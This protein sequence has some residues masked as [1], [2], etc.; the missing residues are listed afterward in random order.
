M[1]PVS[2]R[3][4]IGWAGLA[5]LALGRSGLAA[6]AS[7][8]FAPAAFEATADSVLL[9]VCGN[10]ASKLRIELEEAGTGR[11]VAG[12]AV[13]LTREGDFTAT[14]SVTGLSPGTAWTYRVLDAESGR[15]LHKPGA[16]K[17]APAG[18][19]PFRFVFTADMEESYQPFSLFDV[20]EKYQ[21]DFFLL[22]GDTI[23]ADH[24]KRGF[25]PSISHYRGKHAANRRDA[26]LQA[27]LSRRTT[28]ATW[29]DH[30]VDDNA[31]G[32]HPN[33]AEG[34]QVFREYWPCRSVAPDSLYRRFEWAGVDFFMLDTRRH[35][36]PQT[37]PEDAAKTMLGAAQKAWLLDGLAASKAPFRFIV[38]TVP[39]GGG[40]ADTWGNYKTE[41][42]EIRRFLAQK[43]MR[44]AIFLTGDY[45]LARDWSNEKLG[46]REYMAG[47]I[48]SFFHYQRTPAAR[49][50][51]EKLGAFHYGDG[52]N[53]G[54]W[55][56][57]PAAGKAELEFVD[58]RGET[59]HRVELAA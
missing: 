2:R 21:P 9:W 23:Y 44:N 26:R 18:P 11:R 28:F 8:A 51:Y 59:M 5:P 38:T 30:E 57:D 34:L 10:E 43:K 13:A 31:H 42:D 16:F 32:G 22:L 1:S 24:P 47:P 35:R 17:T 48:A 12:P 41:R 15:E 36:S 20:M 39:F 29:D 45:H 33:M 56:V 40:G 7:L 49:D 4:F 52:P 19:A 37:A 25:S 6:G 27:F 50:R 14:A 54:A 46:I 53:F 3:E 55:R 58:A